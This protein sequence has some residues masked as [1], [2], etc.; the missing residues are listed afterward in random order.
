MGAHNGMR[1]GRWFTDLDEPPLRALV[2]EVPGPGVNRIDVT[3][4]A[5]PGRFD[6]KWLNAWCVRGAGRVG[7][8]L[9]PPH[10]PIR[11]R[12]PAGHLL[13]QVGVTKRVVQH[14]GARK[15]DVWYMSARIEKYACLPGIPLTSSKIWPYL[16]PS[17]SS[18]S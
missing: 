6:E 18:R 1:G 7:H 16:M 12:N 17:R 4:D 8:G 9:L 3:D 11:L 10:K 5:H 13:I 14:P 2:A 15:R